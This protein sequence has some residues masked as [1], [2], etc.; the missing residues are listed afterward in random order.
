MKKAKLTILTFLVLLLGI[1]PGILNAQTDIFSDD[2]VWGDRT[3]YTEYNSANWATY[4]YGEN[5]VYAIMTSNINPL[6]YSGDPWFD[7]DGAETEYG[8]GSGSAL[9]EFTHVEG[10][11]FTNFKVTMSVARPWFDEA[12]GNWDAGIIWG[13]VD[14]LNFNYVNFGTSPSPTAA[15]FVEGEGLRGGSGGLNITINQSISK[16]QDTLFHVVTLEKVGSKVILKYEGTPF[17]SV[18]DASIDDAGMIGFG[19]WNDGGYFDDITVEAITEFVGSTDVSVTT[20]IGTLADDMIAD[21]PEGTTVDQLLAALTLPAGA[22]AMVLNPDESGIKMAVD[23]AEVVMNTMT[24]L[25]TSEAGMLKEYGL[26]SLSLSSDVT[27]A[28]FFS[29]LEYDE[30]T[31]VISTIEGTTVEIFLGKIRP[32]ENATE[33]IFDGSTEVTD[34]AALVATGMVYRVTAE[35][36]V[37]TKDYGIETY[38]PPYPTYS[39]L[40]VTDANPVYIDAFFDEWYTYDNAIEITDVNDGE[41][42]VAPESA[43]DLSAKVQLLWDEDYLY[44]YF[45]VVDQVFVTTEA[46]SWENDGIEFALIMTDKIDKRSGYNMFYLPD[47]QPGNEKLLYIYGATM[48]QTV[49]NGNNT[50]NTIRDFNGASLEKWDLED[51][52]NGY[53]LEMALPW[54]ALNGIGNENPFI[55]EVGNKFTTNVAINDNDG[56]GRETILLLFATNMNQDASNFPLI[57]LD[58]ETGIYN[59]LAGKLKLYPNPVSDF[60]QISGIENVKYVEITNVSGQ[61][62]RRVS[63]TTA[64]GE[65]SINVSTLNRGL[66]FVKVVDRNDHSAVE[67]FLKE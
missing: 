55:P 9:G 49:S 19:S 27:I 21:V 22:S 30:G 14:D 63:N 4:L 34:P 47:Q 44:A 25:V 24:L 51:G 36:G 40:K 45:R 60:L 46:N 5:T 3:N 61:L 65:I 50:A 13:Y 11:N 66:Y 33:A 57:R 2:A 29:P 20:S 18:D 10:Q 7:P 53:E 15:A 28:A 59:A 1:L 6:H 31:D 43:A 54:T 38:A 62:L 56:A 26:E 8:A 39:A 42:L 58:G 17:L 41:G 64:S 12:N 52:D 35:D 67:K 23:G 16:F 48:A 37:T 32:Q